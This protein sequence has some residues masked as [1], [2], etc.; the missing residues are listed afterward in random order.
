LLCCS[1][2][3]DRRH[4]YILSFPTRRSSDLEHNTIVDLLRN[5]L[6]RVSKNVIVKKFRYIDKIKNNRK[7]LLHL[8]SEIEGDLGDAYLDEIGDRKSTRLNS[9]HV[10]ISY[11]VFC[12]KKIR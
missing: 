1:L 10:S 3:C 7:N 5:D 2:L 8:S 11:A 12:L 9:S 6:S 4:T